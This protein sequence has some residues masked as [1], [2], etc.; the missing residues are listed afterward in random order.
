MATFETATETK[1][2]GEFVL[3]LLA[4]LVLGIGALIKIEIVKRLGMLS[5]LTAAAF[6]GLVVW[7]RP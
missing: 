2:I 6:A 1:R 5:A 3:V 7:L 4:C